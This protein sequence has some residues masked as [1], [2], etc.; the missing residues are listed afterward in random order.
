VIHLAH[1]RLGPN[2]ELYRA[3]DGGPL[4]PLPPEYA[5]NDSATASERP[6]FCRAC[7]LAARAL[8]RTRE[9]RRAYDRILPAVSEVVGAD[10]YHAR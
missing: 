3:C 6:E 8:G 2:G 10:V 7:V 1:H 5:L 9:D 4:D